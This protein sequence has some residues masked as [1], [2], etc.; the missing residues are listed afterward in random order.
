MAIRSE[1]ESLF[2]QGVLSNKALF[3]TVAATIVLQLLT[4]YVPA[5]NPVFRTQPLS[6]AEL[7]V[8]LALS[9]VVFFAV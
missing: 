2:T 4:V 7:A 3:L 1:Y 8:V 9:S 6:F 5:L